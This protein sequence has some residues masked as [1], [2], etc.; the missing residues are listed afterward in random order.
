MYQVMIMEK[1]K[2]FEVKQMAKNTGEGHRNGAVG[3]KE[4]GNPRSQVD[5]PSGPRK[6]DGTT[7][8]FMAG[9]KDGKPFKGVRKE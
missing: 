8:Q 3:S 5:T 7:G 9:K 4:R 6:R 1:I 2:Y